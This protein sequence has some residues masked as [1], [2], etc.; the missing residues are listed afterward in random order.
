MLAV[1]SIDFQSTDG[2]DADDFVGEMRKGASD[3]AEQ[4]LRVQP[5]SKI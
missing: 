1:S 3:F 5:S 2:W 4:K